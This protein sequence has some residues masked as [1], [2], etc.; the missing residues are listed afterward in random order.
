MNENRKFKRKKITIN[1]DCDISK[2]QK[3]LDTSTSDI[4][5]GGMCLVTRKALAVG[6]QLTMKF[7]IPDTDR[8]IIV[9]GKVIW[10]EK[11]L[12]KNNA[13]NYYNGIQFIN[14]NRV[15]RDFIEKYIESTTF[16]DKIM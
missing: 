8:A 12:K 2:D 16:D 1:V 5:A 11:F 6:F 9:D 4:S 15:D 7:L 3:W 10:H 13:E 14:I